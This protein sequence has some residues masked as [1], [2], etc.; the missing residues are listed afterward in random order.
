MADEKTI[1]IL[2]G[3]KISTLIIFLGDRGVGKSSLIDSYVNK[4]F[5]KNRQEP[6]GKRFSM[7][8][9]F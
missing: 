1:Y 9:L 4:R 6:F 2:V 8:Y 5:L 3:G 7:F